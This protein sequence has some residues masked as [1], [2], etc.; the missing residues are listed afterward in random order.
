MQQKGKIKIYA[1]ENTLFHETGIILF[2]Q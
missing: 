1:V 2:V